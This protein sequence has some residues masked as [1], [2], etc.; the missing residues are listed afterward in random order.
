MIDAYHSRKCVLLVFL[1]Q[2]DECVCEQQRQHICES[3][4]EKLKTLR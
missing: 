3:R 2:E 1:L 4:E